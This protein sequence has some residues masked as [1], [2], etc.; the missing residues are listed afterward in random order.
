MH[1]QITLSLIQVLS[2]MMS[3]IRGITTYG[4]VHA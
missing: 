1:V 4:L 2:L 3:G